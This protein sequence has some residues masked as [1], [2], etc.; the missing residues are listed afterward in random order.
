VREG[1]EGLRQGEPAH[2]L[3]L[4]A[5]PRAGL[6]GSMII[7]LDLIVATVCFCALILCATACAAYLRE[8]R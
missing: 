8:K 4:D 5:L 1:R 6:E 3:L 7:A 2:P